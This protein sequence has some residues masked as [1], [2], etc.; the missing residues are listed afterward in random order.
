MTELKG[1]EL[2]KTQALGDIHLPKLAAELHVAESIANKLIQKRSTA[3]A[4]VQTKLDKGRSERAIEWDIFVHDMTAK[5]V[6]IDNK[7][8]E[9]QEEIKDAFK[10]TEDKIFSRKLEESTN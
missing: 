6:K 9:K 7:F 5:C 3:D 1:A 8:V 2:Q 10:K 4:D